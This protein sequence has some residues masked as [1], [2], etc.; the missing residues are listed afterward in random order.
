M[1]DSFIYT[2]GGLGQ[3]LM[4]NYILLI[5]LIKRFEAILNTFGSE[6][7]KGPLGRLGG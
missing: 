3:F 5:I 1:Q 2:N 7:G 4:R 6:M